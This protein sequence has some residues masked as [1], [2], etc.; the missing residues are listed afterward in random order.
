MKIVKKLDSNLVSSKMTKMLMSTITV[1]KRITYIHPHSNFA[2]IYN[3]MIGIVFTIQLLSIPYFIA[4]N[5]I[6]VTQ[7]IIFD[8]LASIVYLIDV[9]L[10]VYYFAIIEDDNLISEQIEFSLIYRQK[11]IFIDLCSAMPLSIMTYLISKYNTSL[12]SFMRLTYI[13]KALRISVLYQ[14]LQTVFEQTLNVKFNRNIIRIL[15]TILVLLYIANILT[16]IFILIG[17]VEYENHTSNW[18]EMNGFFDNSCFYIY[19]RGYYLIL[20]TVTT[21][22]YILYYLYHCFYVISWIWEYQDRI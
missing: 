18:I 17:F 13:I 22:I 11:F 16:C 5:D 2:H 20:Y 12:Y 8:S 21:G 14:N 6:N 3:V 15:S 10:N 4:F 9:Y 19:L 7:Q 1:S